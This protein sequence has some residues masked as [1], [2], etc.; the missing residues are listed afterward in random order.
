[1]NGPKIAAKFGGSSVAGP[2]E[3]AKVRQIVYDWK[4]QCV[5]V[6]APGQLRKNGQKVTDMLY[7]IHRGRL[8]E[9]EIRSIFVDIEK[10]YRKIISGLRL[11]PNL[12]DLD[13]K[14][15]RRLAFKPDCSVDHFVSRGEYLNAIVMAEV[16][17]Y[18][19][20]D[21]VD[22]VSFKDGELD[23][24]E[25]RWRW[26]ALDLKDA[27]CVIPGFYGA[28]PDGT[29]KTFTRGGSDLTGAIVAALIGADVYQNWTD[30]PGLLGAPPRIVPHAKQVREVTFKEIRELAYSGAEVFHPLAMAP[31]RE[32]GIPVNLRSTNCPDGR[33]VF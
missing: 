32:A 31:L 29:I 33:L 28:N 20:I 22:F 30:V 7:R 8:S 17:G 27:K 16:L 25:T 15:L 18:K 11:S 3:V 10:R 5:V 2:E 19:C 1:M 9:A 12:L 13:L 26:N 14:E 6:S 24:E 4:I 23:M 21:A